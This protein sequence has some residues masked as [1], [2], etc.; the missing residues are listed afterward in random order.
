M[1]DGTLLEPQIGVRVST[2]RLTAIGAF[3]VAH[4]SIPG[5]P[6]PARHA[7]LLASVLAAPRYQVA[8]GSG[9]RHEAGGTDVVFGRV[10]AGVRA[11]GGQ[12]TGNLL[13][14]H[15]LSAYRDAAD[16]I[17][18]VG[19]THG[20]GGGMHLGLEMRAEDLEGFWSTEEAEGGARLFVGPAIAVHRAGS[21]WAVRAT[22]GTDLRATHSSAAAFVSDA[23]R[24]IS[25]SGGFAM[26]VAFDR[27]F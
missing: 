7:E 22:A 2:G 18:T 21:R 24:L 12:L 15:A 25:T 5:Q 16:M 17:T 20:V 10:V 27:S 3:D 13:V 8:A 26:R 6:P 9:V 23:A 19:W 1:F 4:V 14:E 11:A